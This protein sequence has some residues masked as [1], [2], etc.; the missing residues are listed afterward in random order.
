[1]ED[2]ATAE[3]EQMSRSRFGSDGSKSQTL[4]PSLSLDT[5]IRYP[6]SIGSRQVADTQ[7]RSSVVEMYICT[8]SA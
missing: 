5:P 2:V 1:M 8:S 7:G 6:T 3:K 4:L